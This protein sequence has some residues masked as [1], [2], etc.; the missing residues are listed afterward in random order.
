MNKFI[1]PSFIIKSSCDRA[2]I[3]TLEHVHKNVHKRNNERFRKNRDFLD[4]VKNDR[5]ESKKSLTVLTRKTNYS[6]QNI[7]LVGSSLQ[8][9]MRSWP[10]IDGSMDWTDQ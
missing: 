2:L 8:G 5:F 7:K 10:E 4:S 3:K 6:T 1:L 9:Q